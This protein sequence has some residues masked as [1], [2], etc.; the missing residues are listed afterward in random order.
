M[1]RDE[2]FHR[3][4][5]ML[6]SIDEI[7]VGYSM[8]DQLSGHEATELW[9]QLNKLA[10]KFSDIKNKAQANDPAFQE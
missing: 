10:N 5:N 4:K 8:G 3:T 7:L 9:M 1:E 6:T 2:F